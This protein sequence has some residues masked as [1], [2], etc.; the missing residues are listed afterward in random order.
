MLCGMHAQAPFY[1]IKK[2]ISNT[3]RIHFEKKI[4]LTLQCDVLEISK[5][6]ITHYDSK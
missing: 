2:D 5:Y 6:N 1:E 3:M 4:R